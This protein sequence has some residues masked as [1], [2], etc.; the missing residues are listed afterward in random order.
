[1]PLR[2]ETDGLERR[3]VAHSGRE[4]KGKDEDVPWSVGS[5]VVDDCGGGVPG[6][7]AE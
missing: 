7:E 3:V 2:V 6:G 4:L 5:F 1:M